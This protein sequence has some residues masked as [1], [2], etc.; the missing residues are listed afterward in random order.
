VPLGNG[1]ALTITLVL[2]VY[3]VYALFF[4]GIP[5]KRYWG[6]IFIGSSVLLINAGVI[7]AQ[8]VVGYLVREK[9]TIPFH[10][11]WEGFLIIYGLSAWYLFC[12]TL[13]GT[14]G[15]RAF[16]KRKIDSDKN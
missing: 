7:I 16:R 10:L 6:M 12:F 15:L 11:G 3:F 14:A 2:I 13:V 1:Y 4:A 9:I 8:V 5:R